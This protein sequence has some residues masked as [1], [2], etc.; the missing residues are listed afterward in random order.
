MVGA[1]DDVHL[2]PARKVGMTAFASTSFLVAT[3]LGLGY[4]GWILPTPG[5]TFATP[6]LIVLGTGSAVTVG[7]LL[8]TGN[9]RVTVGILA[10]TLIASWWTLEF[11]VPASVTWDPGADA[12]AVS[13]LGHPDSSRCTRHP[14]G[15]VGR[16]VAPYVECATSSAVGD[17]VTF[18]TTGGS[19]GGIGYTD[20]GEAAFEDE[21]V[22]HLSGNWW[23]FTGQIAGTPGGCP[24]GYQFSGGG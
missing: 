5:R 14:A 7:C 6:T 12:K 10:I 19:R 11:S 13:A 18:A 15:R 16:I 22:R 4:L 3:I 21:C 17:V 9:R 2:A 20:I 8:V 23:T 24:F 1:A